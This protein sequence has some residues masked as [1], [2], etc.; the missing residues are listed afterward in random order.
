MES[1]FKIM[2]GVW[3]GIVTAAIV[4]SLLPEG[5]AGYRR[6]QI[7]AMN[8]VIKYELKTNPDQTVEWVKKEN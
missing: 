4:N 3:I 8:G 1:F 7:D 2:L 6:G 5:S